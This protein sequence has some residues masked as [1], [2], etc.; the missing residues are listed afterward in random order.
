MNTRTPLLRSRSPSAPT[1][2][3]RPRKK[4]RKLAVGSV[5][6]YLTI[7]DPSDEPRDVTLPCYEFG[8]ST[9]APIDTGRLLQYSGVDR[10]FPLPINPMRQ[11]GPYRF[12]R[13]R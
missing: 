2:V 1:D 8:L 9:E 13:D 4:R 6:W 12:W 5:C 3:A 10:S 11:D 7:L